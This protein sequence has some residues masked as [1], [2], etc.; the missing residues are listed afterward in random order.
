MRLEPRGGGSRLREVLVAY[1]SFWVNT[2]RQ[3]GDELGI[4]RNGSCF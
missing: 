4:F 2:L 1:K 3:I